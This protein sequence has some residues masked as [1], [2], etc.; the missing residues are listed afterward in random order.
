MEMKKK[1]EVAE[2]KVI[3]FECQDILTNS[4]DT[5]VPASELHSLLHNIIQNVR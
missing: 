1:F 2:V 3:K 4:G 5:T